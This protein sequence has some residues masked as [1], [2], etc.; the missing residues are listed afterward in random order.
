MMP[1]LC[2]NVISGGCHTSNCLACPEFS[3]VPTGAR[4]VA[5]DMITDTEFYHT[6]KFGHEKDVRRD[7][8]NA[9]DETD[10]APSV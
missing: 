8:C 9:G 10:F 7:A 5:E 3:I 4:S 2:F 1:V 6:L